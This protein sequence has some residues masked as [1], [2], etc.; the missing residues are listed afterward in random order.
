MTK[1]DFQQGKAF[2]RSLLA[3]ALVFS[4]LSAFGQA[5]ARMPQPTAAGSFTYEA[6]TI[7]PDNS[8]NGSWRYRLDGFSTS[9]MPAT[10]LIRNA[11]GLLT[12]DQIVGLPAWAKTEPLAVQAK[13][14][15]DT[16]AA[17]AKLPPEEF[18]KQRQLMMQLLL[19][20]RFALK[21]HHA[22]KDL[23]TY[24]L[25]VAKT[26]SMLKS[27]ASDTGGNMMNGSARIDA[28]AVSMRTLAANLSLTVG[29]IVVDKTGL[30]GSY[31]FTVDF[32]PEGADPSDPRPSIFT[33]LEEQLGL[34]LVPSKGPVDV[35]VVD[36]VERPSEN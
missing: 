8:G 30:E 25:V 24:E 35:I 32:A 23:P 6:V 16:A 2:P 26:G 9:G 17:L 22:Q 27:S 34:K 1:R 11:F 14:D 7:K 5:T 29:R 13:M 21:V 20:Q 36:H 33:A 15:A 28:R 10:N 31:D 18:L 19:A 12:D 3:A 4:A